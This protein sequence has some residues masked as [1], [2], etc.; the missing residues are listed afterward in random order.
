MTE[1]LSRE[2]TN[3]LIQTIDDVLNDSAEAAELLTVVELTGTE[4]HKIRSDFF[5]KV[6]MHS[7]SVRIGCQKE[8]NSITDLFNEY[9]KNLEN[10]SSYIN[11]FEK[12][13]LFEARKNLTDIIDGLNKGFVQF[14]NQAL[15]LLGPSSHGGINELLALCR[16][17]LQGLPCTEELSN[18]MELQ[19]SIAGNILEQLQLSPPTILTDSLIQFN[20]DLGKTLEKHSPRPGVQDPFLLAQLIR[21]L[22]EIGEHYKYID[23][24]YLSRELS[25]LPTIIPY[26]NLIMNCSKLLIEGKMKG[27]FILFTIRDFRDLIMSIQ[28]GSDEIRSVKLPADTIEKEGDRMLTALHELSTALDCYENALSRDEFSSLQSCEK[29]MSDAAC[30]FEIAYLVMKDIADAEG[31]ILC[32]K[33]GAR[34]TPGNTKC[35][36]C[37]TLLPA[38]IVED[39]SALDIRERSDPSFGQGGD[40]QMTTTVFRLFD[41]AEALVEQIIRKEEFLAI[42]Q[43]IEELVKRAASAIKNA[44]PSSGKDTMTDIAKVEEAQAIYQEALDDF[45]GGLE[46]FRAFSGSLSGETMDTAREK[47]WSGLSKLQ[48]IQRLLSPLIQSQLNP[49]AR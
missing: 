19:K 21:A 24:G 9:G 26:A 45:T 6:A 34:N 46:L 18:S 11:S 14:R 44:P 39:L 12:A 43:K 1:E 17:V 2:E 25:Q 28:D 10:L 30:L 22:E 5:E 33:C 35:H 48:A 32:I 38:L 27:D 8:I 20:N 36:N 3:K 23:I 49:D 4:L 31:L 16:G 41:S 42:I 29:A 13:I 7:P 15:I 37:N 47:I 40:T